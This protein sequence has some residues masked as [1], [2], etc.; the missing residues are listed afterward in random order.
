MSG[1]N[2]DHGA[3][4]ATRRGKLIIVFAITFAVMVAEII[5]AALTGS[6]ALLA[7]AG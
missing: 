1:H 4:A 2:H 5:G 3:E 7:D 6:L